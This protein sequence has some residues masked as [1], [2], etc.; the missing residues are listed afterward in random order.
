VLHNTS[1]STPS[2][3]PPTTPPGTPPTSPPAV[4]TGDEGA[5]CVVYT[6]LGILILVGVFLEV[7]VE[8]EDS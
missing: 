3:I 8:L 4:F 5:Y 7:D 6:A 2:G 1:L